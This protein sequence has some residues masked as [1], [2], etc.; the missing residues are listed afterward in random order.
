MDSE[1]GY[2]APASSPSDASWQPWILF[3]NRVCIEATHDK[4][5]IS[6]VKLYG[7]ISLSARLQAL[8]ESHIASK[9]PRPR[10]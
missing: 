3:A 8:W 10:T 5:Y 9:N 6:S 2:V 7:A 4:L 1:K